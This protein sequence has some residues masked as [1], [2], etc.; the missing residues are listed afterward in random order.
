MNIF[1]IY[2]RSFEQNLL[3]L[4]MGSIS[5]EIGKTEGVL[6]LVSISRIEQVFS[7]C[8]ECTLLSRLRNSY[9]QQCLSPRASS[10]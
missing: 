10:N 4:L 6:F 9:V 7:Q 5:K 8:L 3:F 1:H 2:T